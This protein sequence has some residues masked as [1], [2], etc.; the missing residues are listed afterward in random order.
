MT[1]SPA[2][3]LHDGHGTDETR[4]VKDGRLPKQLGDF[5][6]ALAMVVLGQMLGFRVA[7]VDHE[8]ADLIASKGDTRLA[9]SVKTR[10]FVTDDPSLVFETP[11]P[12]KLTLFAES[13]GLEPAVAF[14]M[15]DGDFTTIDLYFLTLEALNRYANDPTAA[16]FGTRKG[17]A[18]ISNAPRNQASLQSL[19]GVQHRRLTVSKP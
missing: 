1:M 14:V 7:L 4:S 2:D 11:N 5:G 18:Y 10:R 17:G 12:E 8:G 13:F 19:D 6:E 3:V 15:I 9:V 16:G